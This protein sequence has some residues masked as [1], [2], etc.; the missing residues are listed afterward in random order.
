MSRKKRLNNNEGYKTVYCR[1]CKFGY[2]KLN[3]NNFCT[4]ECALGFNSLCAEIYNAYYARFSSDPSL[5]ND[6][7]PAGAPKRNDNES[8]QTYWKRVIKA[9]YLH[10]SSIGAVTLKKYLKIADHVET[11]HYSSGILGWVNNNQKTINN[12]NISSCSSSSSSLLSSSSSSNLKNMSDDF[13]G[14][15]SFFL[16]FTSNTLPKKQKIK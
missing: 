13:D 9:L 1:A 2:K 6:Y 10:P 14:A 12:N 4:P 3:F 15:S 5:P 16:N 11:E 7:Q 8:Y